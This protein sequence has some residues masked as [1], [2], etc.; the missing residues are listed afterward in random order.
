MWYNASMEELTISKD[1]APKLLHLFWETTLRCNS[2]CAHCGSDCGRG[3]EKEPLTTQEIK[4]F[5]SRVAED[6][7]PSGILVNVT[8]GEPLLREDL[9]E[10]M[11][12]AHALGF[13]WTM[14]TNG[15]LITEETVEK[16]RQSGMSTVSVSLDGTAQIHDRFRGGRGSF[17]RAARG[18]RLLASSGCFHEVQVTTVVHRQ[19]LQVLEAVYETVQALGA[20]S[21]RV[22]NIE[23]IGRARQHPELL[24]DREG[25]KQL[26]A[27]ISEKREFSDFPVTYGCAHYLGE[28]LERE[29]RLRPWPFTCLAGTG[30]ASVAYNGD[31]L[32][33]LSIEH[34]P[35]LIQGNIRRDDFSDVWRRGFTQ[36]R[37][38]HHENSPFCAGC[39]H[40]SKCGGDS[41]HTWD[42]ERNR[43]RICLKDIL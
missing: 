12:H 15:S 23:P 4:T 13:S 26:L 20:D 35:E 14:T 25:W 27:F 16:L 5:F 9:F 6:F 8:G 37:N 1:V 18:I 43:P 17:A 21:W 41:F 19:N 2:A 36:Y 29:R 24:L 10:V 28:T 7:D 33:C 31:I 40:A 42:F 32:S 22:I 11:A 34:R 39:I 30:V 38:A 3:E